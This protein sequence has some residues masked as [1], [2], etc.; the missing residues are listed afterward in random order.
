MLDLEQE[1]FI[2]GI[3]YRVSGVAQYKSKH[4]RVIRTTA[5][6]A[7]EGEDW[8]ILDS[9]ESPVKPHVVA[10]YL[11]PHRQQDKWHLA[12]VRLDRVE[13]PAQRTHKYS[14]IGRPQQ[15]IKVYFPKSVPKGGSNSDN[16]PLEEGTSTVCS[17]K[18]LQDQ[19]EEKLQS[20]LM[21]T[22]IFTSIAMPNRALREEHEDDKDKGN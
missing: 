14:F 8:V 3:P 17:D 15:D 1:L 19:P 20:A 11:N 9:R 6:V 16:S 5:G 10:Q 2:K 22:K 21:I 12:C 13:P 7:G 18:E 4:F